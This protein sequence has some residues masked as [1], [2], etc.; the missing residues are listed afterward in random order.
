M[1]FELGKKNRQKK[2]LV[3]N[4]FLGAIIGTFS[5][6]GTFVGSYIWWLQLQY[7]ETV[8]QFG[9]VATVG[10]FATFLFIFKLFSK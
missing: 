9:I 7:P 3:E 6:M 8:H 4:L 10:F 2:R 5:L 1:K